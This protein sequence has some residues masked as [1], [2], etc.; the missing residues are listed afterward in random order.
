[1]VPPEQIQDDNGLSAM[2]LEHISLS[3]RLTCEMNGRLLQGIRNVSQQVQTHSTSTNSNSLLQRGGDDTG[4]VTPQHHRVNIH[5]SRSWQ[6][7][8][9]SSSSSAVVEEEQFAN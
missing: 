1:M 5:P 6:P 8:I 4:I 7:P 2:N 9:Q 3:F